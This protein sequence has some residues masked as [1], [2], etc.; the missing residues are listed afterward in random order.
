MVIFFCCDVNG[1]IYWCDINGNTDCYD[2][3]GYIYWCDIFC[4]MIILIILLLQ[5]YF[6]LFICISAFMVVFSMY[7]NGRLYSGDIL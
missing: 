4:N 7:H 5:M 6:Y 2:I 1:N 3:Y